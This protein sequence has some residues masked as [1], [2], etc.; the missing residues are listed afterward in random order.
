MLI[1]IWRHCQPVGWATPWHFCSNPDCPKLTACYKYIVQGNGQNA[2]THKDREG[3]FTKLDKVASKVCKC[4]G[5]AFQMFLHL[6]IPLLLEA[7]KL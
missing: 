6:V 2:D 4:M 3:T 1:D 7:V 5:C